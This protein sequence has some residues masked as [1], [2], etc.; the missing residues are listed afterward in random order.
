MSSR[1]G[2]FR[3][4][5]LAVAGV[6]VLALALAVAAGA[7]VVGIYTNSFNTKPQFREI[8][9]I[10]KS[11]ACRKTFKA[12][13]KSMEIR[14]RKAPRACFYRP[15]VQGSNPRPDHRLDV[16]GKII[17][18]TPKAIRGDAY[19]TASL[20][21]GDGRRYELRVFPKGKR[22]ELRRQPTNAGFPVVGT[23][24]D[25]RKVGAVNKIRLIATGGQI[26][27][28]ANGTQIASVTDPNPGQLDGVKI[29]F[30]IGNE[31]D[32]GRNTEGRINRVKVSVPAP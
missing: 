26:R 16:D 9:Q 22:F 31:A 21:V 10:T 23:H 11:E 18:S 19:L 3:L 27:G 2:H 6:A 28:I 30:G 25:I 17:V 5:I 32:S 13:A 29:Q 12:A 8:Q 24:G 4:N 14:V 7:A 20:R 1:R 15:P